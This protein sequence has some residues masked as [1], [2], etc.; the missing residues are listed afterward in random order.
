MARTLNPEAHAVRRDVFVDAAQRLIM[1][2]GYEQF[3]VQDVLE[4][5]EASKGAFYHYFDS[6]DALVDAVVNRMADQATFELEPI[7]GDPVMRAAEKLERLFG[8]L[9]RFKAERK[10]LVLGILRVW[11]SDDNAVV[12]EKLR[13]IVAVRLVP[14]LERIVRQGVAEGAFSSRYP[15]YLARVLATLVQGMSE[16]ASQLWVDRQTGAV[17]LEEVKRTFDAYLEAFERI[18]GARPGSL[19]FLDEPTIE[20]WFG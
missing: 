16:L 4:L 12:R 7:L 18:V 5:S 9:A 19:K 11:Q 17:S 15:D 14:W 6:K 3:S 2:R 13:R 10:D 8:G 1:S 20:F